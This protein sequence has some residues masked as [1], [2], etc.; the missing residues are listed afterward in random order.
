MICCR[1]L[2]QNLYLTLPKLIPVQLKL[3]PA[4]LKLILVKQHLKLQVLSQGEDKL[5]VVQ[6][7]AMLEQQ[8]QQAELMLTG[9]LLQEAK[10]SV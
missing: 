4:Q 6:Q 1:Q 5:L 10:T 2:I 8:A 9:L 3:I 7:Q